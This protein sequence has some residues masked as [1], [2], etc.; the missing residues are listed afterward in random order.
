MKKIY[1]RLFIIFIIISMVLSVG[2]IILLKTNVLLNFNYVGKS[3]YNV[4]SYL[5]N[6]NVDNTHY[7]IYYPT[8]LLITSEEDL[9]KNELGID[10]SGMDLSQIDFESN[11]A[12]L[13]FGAELR[14]IHPYN[15]GSVNLQNKAFWVD[16]YV[17]CW[18][19]NDNDIYIYKIDKYNI[20]KNMLMPPSGV[21]CIL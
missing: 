4:Q 11:Y 7:S 13:T 19:I 2:K 16:V 15:I 21:F 10:L 9:N 8:W 18:G 6:L 3:L 14:A 12:V 17:K 5:S 20:T 1:K